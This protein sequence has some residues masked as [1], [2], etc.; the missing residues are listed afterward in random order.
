VT[1]CNTV[2][3]SSHRSIKAL[4]DTSHAV[5]LVGWNDGRLRRW[6]EG[7]LLGHSVALVKR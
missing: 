4:E 6:R 7:S 5:A 1:F 3:L 2:K